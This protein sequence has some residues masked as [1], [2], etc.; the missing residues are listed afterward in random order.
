MRDFI[1]RHAGVLRSIHAQTSHVLDCSGDNRLCGRLAGEGQ[2]CAFIGDARAWTPAQ[3]P[4]L[5]AWY[6]ADVGVYTD[7]GCSTPATNTQTIACWADQSGNG[8]NLIQATGANQP[9]FLST[10]YDGKQTVQCNAATPVW[11]TTASGVAMGT[12]TTGSGFAVGQMLTGT[13]SNGRVVSY[14]GSN[15]D[16]N[17]GG[18]VILS[19]NVTNSS[20]TTQRTAGV[21]S[22][23]ISLATNMHFGT[24]LDGTNANWYINNVLSGTPSALANV[25]Q[26]AG[27]LAV[28]HG[29]GTSGSDL[30]AYWS[31]PISEIVVTNHAISSTD[32]ANLETWFSRW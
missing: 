1:G 14:S 29:L 15:S 26:N 17:T 2:R 28:C 9:E 3:L 19:R 13:S 18:W 20:L 8:A 30:G 10:G 25:T 31:G 24:V 27:R 12:N 22:G 5:V 32:R 11:M 16:F 23:T 6:R 4:G 21:N 7:T